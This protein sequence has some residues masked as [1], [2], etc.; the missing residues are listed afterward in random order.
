MRTEYDESVLHQTTHA[1][2]HIYREKFPLFLFLL[3]Y[4]QLLGNLT[5]NEDEDQV[6]WAFDSSNFFFR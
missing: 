3:L 4:I 6:M 1:N 2:E 5:L